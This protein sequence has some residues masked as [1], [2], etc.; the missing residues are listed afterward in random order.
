LA[1]ISIQ[2]I[3]NGPKWIPASQNGH[4]VA[5]YRLQPVTLSNSNKKVQSSQNGSNKQSTSNNPAENDSEA[6]F[7][8]LEKQASFP[9]GQSTW[10]KYISRAIQKNGN[11]LI[12]DKNSQGTC[13]VQFIV[14]K[15][16]KV[17][18][19]KAITKQG[20]ELADVAINAIMHGPRWIPGM[21]NGHLVNSYVIQPVRFL[22][23][24][25]LI[26]NEPE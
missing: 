9:G 8:K 25:H 24:D 1:K 14:S 6:S 7:T 18:D 23:N 13:K 22:L 11:E 15:D 12:A 26:E 17:S 10:L 5:S 3:K 20:S 16:G 4:T 19:V 2:A 21:Q